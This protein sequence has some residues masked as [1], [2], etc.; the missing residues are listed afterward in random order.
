MTPFF[1]CALPRSRTAWLANFL[2]YG[3]AFCFHEALLGC[4]SVDDLKPLFASA[5]AQGAAVVGNSD[6]GNALVIDRLLSVF[7]GARVVVVERPI[8][9]CIA[10]LRDDL[11]IEQDGG[12]D[13]IARAL[14]R[15]KQAH[16]PLVVRY[17][18]LDQEATARAIWAHCVGVPFDAR[19]WSM[20]DG[21]VVEV[22]KT[23]FFNRMQNNA[24]NIRAFLEGELCLG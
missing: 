24:A 10:S 14:D 22:H 11:G 21:L 19:R 13:L 3:G 4:R 6:C 8:D 1:I 23:K 15:I 20:L 2:T 7:P 16:D 9:E 5:H 18:D 17:S 12:C